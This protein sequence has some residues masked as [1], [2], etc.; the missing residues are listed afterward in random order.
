[1]PGI[2]AMKDASG[3][4]DTFNEVSQ[5][6]ALP[7]LSGDDSL[8]LPFM[9]LGARGVISV[10]SNLVPEQ[11]V[12]MV[13]AALAGDFATA[14]SLHIKLYPLFKNAFIET[15]PVPIKRAMQ[16]AGIIPAAGVRLPLVEL[17]ADSD[18]KWQKVLKEAGVIA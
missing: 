5:L 6:C 14:R 10:V 4:M 18:A 2:I 16:L 12:K 15:N 8:T 17:A 1:M 11:L 3:G 13:G 7:H 9:A